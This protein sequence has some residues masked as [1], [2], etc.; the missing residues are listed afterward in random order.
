MGSAAVQAGEGSQARATRR[1]RVLQLGRFWH[2]Q[3]G[4]VERQVD[5][6]SRGL[7]AEG[8]EV[9]N[10]VAAEGL[11]GG[12]AVR[13]GYRLVHAGSFGMFAG[14]ALS[15]ALIARA[16]ALHRQ[17]PFDVVHL[18]LPDPVSHAL[19]WLLP[20]SV[21]R[22]ITWHSDIVRQRRLLKLYAPFLRRLV[23]GADAVVAATRS[24]FDSSTQ[25]PV[26]FPEARRHVIPYAIDHAALRLDA[27]TEALARE[28]R[29]RAGGRMLVLA[30]GRHVYYKGFAVLVEA[31]RQCDAFLVLGGTGPLR[32]GLQEQAKRLGV[33]ERIWFPGRLPEEDLPGWYHACDVFC[34]P[35]VEASEAFGLVQLEAMACGKPVVNTWLG[36]GVNEVSLDGVTGLT[37]PP[38]DAGALA[39][40]IARLQG[41]AA[42]RARLGEAARERAQGRY[43]VEAMAA[44]HLA[45]YRGLACAKDRG[46]G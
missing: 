19:A 5:L 39:G 8:V 14:T 10:L 18:H 38:R 7:A 31:M 36:N 26:A 3:H 40:A 27:R 28:I 43:S 20:R 13:D 21:K 33:A 45:L 6:L 22:V 9:V 12:D 32:D 23:L 29:A 4:G 42:L 16:L 1:L 46:V 17:D 25:I 35:S 24:H 11:R 34:L 44:A 2:E 30:L 37:V 15:P 41:D